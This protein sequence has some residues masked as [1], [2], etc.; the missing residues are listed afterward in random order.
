MPVDLANLRR[1]IAA[2]EEGLSI[3]QREQ[4]SL[5]DPTLQLLL[6]DAAIQRFEF[7][8]ETAWKTLK[9]YLQEYGLEQVDRATNRQIFRMGYEQG[10]LRDAE[11][12][13]LYLRQRNLTSHVYDQSVAE[14]IFRTIPEF[15]ED[16]RWML[17][18]LEERLT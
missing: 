13:L 18:R 6:R 5:A 17:A 10:L 2:L 16:A 7:T 1:A 9:R 14:A 4:S 3:F 12:W 11:A 15:L 8:F